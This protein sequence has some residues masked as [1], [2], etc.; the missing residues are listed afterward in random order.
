MEKRLQD[1]L[2]ADRQW[3]RAHRIGHAKYMKSLATTRDDKQF[4]IAVLEANEAFK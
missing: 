2:K 3:P 4:W 1:Y